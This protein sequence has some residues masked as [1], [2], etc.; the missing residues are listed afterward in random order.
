MARRGH[1][2]LIVEF[3]RL[4]GPGGHCQQGQAD[5]PT[6][7]PGREQAAQPLAGERGEQMIQHSGGENAEQDGVGLAVTQRQHQG[8]ELRLVADLAETDG[9]D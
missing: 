4:Q 8:Q 9:G 2:L 6:Q 5:T 3:V 1:G 7:H